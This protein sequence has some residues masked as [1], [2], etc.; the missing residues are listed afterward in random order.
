MGR[1]FA[2]RFLEYQRFD[3]RFINLDPLSKMNIL[4]A[5]GLSGLIVREWLFGFSICLFLVVLSIV[6]GRGKQFL[7]LFAVLC[8]LFGVFIMA[9]RLFSVKGVTVL[10][11]VF[12]LFDITEEALLAGLNIASS[13][14][15][16]SGTIVLF[17]I[18]TEIRDLMYSLEKKGVSHSVSYIILASFQTIKDLKKNTATIMDSQKARGIET[19]GN[20]F[21]RIKAFFPI[22]GPLMLGAISGTEEKL[23]AMDARAFSA[24]RKNTFLRELR[25]VPGYEKIIVFLVD[26]FV[27]LSITYKILLVLAN[28]GIIKWPL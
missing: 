14:L 28:K 26:L 4:F 8:V 3:N 7:K 18:V 23:I 13:M 27:L 5:L 17:F 10:F 21:N 16:F 1:E 12:G 22:L 19:E 25:P 20:V 24:R 11:S 15:S 6:I 9:I 2:E